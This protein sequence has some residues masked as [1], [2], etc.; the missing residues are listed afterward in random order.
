MRH[1]FS[2]FRRHVSCAKIWPRLAQFLQFEL[3]NPAHW[4][5]F[6]FWHTIPQYLLC[7]TRYLCQILLMYIIFFFTFW[8]VNLTFDHQNEIFNLCF[9]LL[10]IYTVVSTQSFIIMRVF[11]FI[12]PVWTWLL[13]YIWNRAYNSVIVCSHH[14]VPM[15]NF[16]N[17]RP[18]STI[19]PGSV[20]AIW[21][22]W[23]W[24]LTLIYTFIHNS[25]RVYIID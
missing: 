3:F 10:S 25:P 24:H 1:N 5:L 22:V 19:W 17:I 7:I 12:W 15:P 11:L 4:P 13:N 21:H 23:P 18:F 9:L 16:I 14:W 20:L 6:T 2:L 8:P